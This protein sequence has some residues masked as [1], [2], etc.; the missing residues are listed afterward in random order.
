M[1]FKYHTHNFSHIQRQHSFRGIISLGKQP[2]THNLVVLLY[3]RFGVHP[4]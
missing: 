1:H 3:W 2:K 4:E